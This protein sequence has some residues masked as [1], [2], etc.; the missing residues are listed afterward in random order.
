MLIVLESS[1]HDPMGAKMVSRQ[2]LVLVMAVTTPLIGCVGDAL[3]THEESMKAFCGELE[4]VVNFV[5]REISGDFRETFCLDAD[6]IRHGRY[7]L[8]YFPHLQPKASGVILGGFYLHGTPAGRW[9]DATG[10]IEGLPKEALPKL[11]V[12]HLPEEVMPSSGGDK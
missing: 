7:E 12:C 10:D 6:G 11:C 1:T 9:I 4:G 5:T 2:M 8:S 3:P